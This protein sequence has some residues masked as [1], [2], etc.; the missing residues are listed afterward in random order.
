[1]SDFG[2]GEYMLLEEDIIK[3]FEEIGFLS[4]EDRLKVLHS[5]DGLIAKMSNESEKQEFR[6]DNQTS[7]EEEKCLT[8]T[9]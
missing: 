5:Y 9:I 3:M 7:M 8:G 1:M 6:Q 2:I 4:K